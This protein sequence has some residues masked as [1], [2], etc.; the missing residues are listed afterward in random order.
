MG[1]LLVLTVILLS[2]P[3]A[4]SAQT[5]GYVVNQPESVSAV[6]GGSVILPCSFSYPRAIEPVRDLRVYW[7][8]DSFHGPVIYNPSEG[9]TRQDY[10]GR[11]SL[12]GDPRGQ[13]TASIRISDLRERDSNWYFCRVGV[14]TNDGKTEVWQSIP[15]TK[16]TVTGGTSTGA[17]ATTSSSTRAQ[18]RTSS[19]TTAQGISGAMKEPNEEKPSIPLIAGAVIGALLLVFIVGISC[20][21]LRRNRGTRQAQKNSTE[22]KEAVELETHEKMKNG[23]SGEPVYSAPDSRNQLEPEGGLVYASLDHKTPNKARTE[24]RRAPLP[25]ETTVYAAV[26]GGALS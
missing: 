5:P 1:T 9:F 22:V 19:S 20:F 26:S 23:G 14:R 13:K 2:R 15:G 21:F 10:A 4:V 25:E 11:I 24:G 6:L 18:A 12:V 7:R 17:Q 3:A 16:L 8:S